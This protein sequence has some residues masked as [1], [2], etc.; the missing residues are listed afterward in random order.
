LDGAKPGWLQLAKDGIIGIKS[1]YLR[2]AETGQFTAKVRDSA[3]A[4]HTDQA[5]FSITA[6]PASRWRHPLR[7][8]SYPEIPQFEIEVRPKWR[9]PSFI[10]VAHLSFWLSIFALGVPTFGAIWIFIYAFTTPGSHGTYLG[11][12]MLTGIAAFVIGCLIGFLFG[13]PRVISSGQ[14]RLGQS[15]DYTPSSNLS[16]VSDWLTKL[17]LGAGLVQL[18]HLG[19]PIGSL[20]NQIAAALNNSAT[21]S[22]AAK[23]AAGTIIFGYVAIGLLDGYVITTL[24][25]QKKLAQPSTPQLAQL[26]QQSTPQHLQPTGQLDS[27][28]TRQDA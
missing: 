27:K 5:S 24:W 6:R 26:A 16:E 13:I 19:K 11:V 1:K 4:P 23:V 21:Y 2:N 3:P 17:L 14:A 20:I 12:A 8:R 9:W 22:G 25:Y 7:P 18:T 10:R 28:K 15:S